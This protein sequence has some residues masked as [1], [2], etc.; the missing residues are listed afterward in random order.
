MNFSDNKKPWTISYKM[1]INYYQILGVTSNAQPELIKF[2][3]RILCNKYH[4]DKYKGSDAHQRMTEI[5]EAY[6]TLSNVELRRD[7]D[8]THTENNNN[9]SNEQRTDYNNKEN[10]NARRN[11]HP[12]W[13]IA[14][15]IYPELIEL[16]YNLAKI[17]SQL[18]VSFKE[19]I[20]KNKEFKNAQYVALK[21]KDDFL[22]THFGMNEEIKNLALGYILD[23]NT[24]AAKEIN[25]LAVLFGNDIVADRIIQQIVFKYGLSENEKQKLREKM[26][27][28]KEQENDFMLKKSPL[29]LSYSTQMKIMFL[30]MILAFIINN[31]A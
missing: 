20:I 16:N 17:S 2:A 29:Q 3:Y 12:S 24:T 21:M 7:Y 19:Y 5:N 27:V 25:K 28:E 30:I 9:D 11:S 10:E 8:A 1:K 26:K 13:Q 31:I 6:N 15:E 22:T 14:I 4:P 18:S 23:K